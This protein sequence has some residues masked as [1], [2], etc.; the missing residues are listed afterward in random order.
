VEKWGIK[1]CTNSECVLITHESQ[2]SPD[3][4][5]YRNRDKNAAKNINEI[6][7]DILSGKDRKIPFTRL[8]SV[9]VARK[10]GTCHK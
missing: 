10:Y 4:S 5:R 2:K 7:K 8:A 3:W 1:R 6:G 9:Q